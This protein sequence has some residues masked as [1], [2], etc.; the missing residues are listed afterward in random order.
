MLIRGSNRERGYRVF[1]FGEVDLGDLIQL[2]AAGGIEE[3]LWR[4]QQASRGN[5][6]ALRTILLGTP[7]EDAPP[8]PPTSRKSGL[9]GSKSAPYRG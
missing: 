1:V 8:P 9:R 7:V 4:D 3:R 5:G 6:A 2:V